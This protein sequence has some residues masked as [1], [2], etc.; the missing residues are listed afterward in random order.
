MQLSLHASEGSLSLPRG[1]VHPPGSAAR[2]SA[3]PLGCPG[4]CSRLYAPSPVP[5]SQSPVPTSLLALKAARNPR[6]KP[7]LVRETDTLGDG[8]SQRE[9]IHEHPFL[10]LCDSQR[11]VAGGIGM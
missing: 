7:D 5:T 1:G 2:P 10:S 9:A 6:S 11:A 8:A 4:H 3:Q